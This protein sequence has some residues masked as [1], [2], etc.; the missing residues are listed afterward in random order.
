MK[1][2]FVGCEYAGATTLM[3]GLVTWS[4]QVMGEGNGFWG[5]HAHW[6]LP[7]NNGHW[8]LD[9]ENFTT[10]EEQA[11]LMALSPK[12]K[13]LIQRHSLAYHT[14]PASLRGDN[15]NLFI[16]LH[17]ENAIYGRRYYGYFQGES[18][19]FER[20]YI[21]RHTDK[22]IMALS[23]ETVLVLVKASRDTIAQ[24][25]NEN[26][27]K[28]HQVPEEDIQEVLDEFQAEFDRSTIE[29]K[30]TIDT[31]DG[32]VEENLADLIK[33][34]EPFFT[35]KDRGRILAEIARK[36]GEWI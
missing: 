4:N 17:I 8:K 9:E 5:Y 30:I 18:G 27:H 20:E 24:R 12:Q 16:G 11:L 13:E 21:L 36:R 26:R 10:P 1:A 15:D 2:I 33:Q 23:P 35:D 32:A 31:T 28:F 14:S 34:L 3:Q 7:D 22:D 19:E 25:I 6:T 29:R